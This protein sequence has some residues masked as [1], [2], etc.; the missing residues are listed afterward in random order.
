[1]AER[2][3]T[4]NLDNISQFHKT[5][6]QAGLSTQIKIYVQNTDE[7]GNPSGDKYVVG[8]IQSLA[9]TET[10]NLIRI[11]EVGTDGVLEIVPQNAATVDIQVTR[12]V[13]DYQRLPAAFQRGFRHI[14]AA[15]LPF[16]IVI[17]DY[18]AYREYGTPPTG[19]KSGGNFVS[20][21]YKNCWLQ[22][23][24]FTY[25]TDNY[26]ITETATIWAE[27]VYDTDSYQGV[28]VAA[29]DSYEKAANFSATAN[30]LTE[31]QAPIS[32]S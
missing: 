21:V 14:H 30:V 2:T 27:T 3:A 1:M 12:L 16:D 9:P 5:G 32:R 8:A 6:L 7:N 19:G 10:R 13:F 31:A 11:S 28:S 26:L 25:Q 22:N 17:E 15:R 23:Y 24:T 29:A 20:T 4:G 18:N